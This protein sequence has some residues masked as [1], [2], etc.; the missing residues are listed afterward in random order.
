MSHALLAPSAAS[1]WTVC[2]ASVRASE[3]LPD[4]SSIFAVRG[5]ILH[6]IAAERLIGKPDPH[7]VGEDVTLEGHTYRLTAEDFDQIKYYEDYIRWLIKESADGTDTYIERRFDMG[8]FIPDGFGTA[9]ATLVEPAGTLTVADAKFG[10]GVKVYADALQLAI[11]AIAIYEELGEPAFCDKIRCIIVQPPLS[12]VDVH[13]YTIDELMAIKKFVAK[14]AKI[15]FGDKGKFVAG[16]Q[17]KFCLK[18]PTCKKI[19]E[20]SLEAARNTFI[21]MDPSGL[22]A[23]MKIV[24]ILEEYIKQVK[25]S[26]EGALLAGADVEGF[27]LVAGRKSRSWIDPEAT[28]QQLRG[29]KVKVADIFDSKLRSPAQMEKILKGKEIDLAFLIKTSDGKPTV[30]PESDKRPATTVAGLVFEDQLL[31]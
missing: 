26:V 15:A 25:S 18:K 16:P 31:K 22:G 12:H 11:Y 5:T 1:R 14:Q 29:L 28:E 9:D 24:P 4:S 17:C 27:K 21:P 13:E 10:S 23:K 3:G 6:D 19:E 30:A 20:I 2:T 8:S 7:A